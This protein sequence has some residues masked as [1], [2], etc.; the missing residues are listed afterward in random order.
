MIKN[1]LTKLQN[2][3]TKILRICQSV[4]LMDRPMLVGKPLRKNYSVHHKGKKRVLKDFSSYKICKQM[5]F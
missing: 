3:Y 4:V 2:R 1:S 5:E